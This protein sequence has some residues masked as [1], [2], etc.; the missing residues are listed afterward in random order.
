MTVRALLL[1]A[2]AARAA[3]QQYPKPGQSATEKYNPEIADT[4][5]RFIVWFHAGVEKKI[6]A[7]LIGSRRH[8]WLM[9][10][11]PHG[12]NALRRPSPLCVEMPR[13]ATPR[14]LSRRFR[15]DLRLHDNP[16]LTA[17]VEHA[18][19]KEVVPVF[20]FDPRQFNEERLGPQPARFLVESVAA[21]RRALIELGSDLLVGVGHPEKLLP[22]L[23]SRAKWAVDAAKAAEI[24]NKT[25]I[26]W[27][28]QV[29]ALDGSATS[30]NLRSI[31]L[32]PASS[33]DAP[34]HAYSRHAYSRHAYSPH[35]YSSP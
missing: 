25:S 4:P 19:P 15:N 29:C 5:H 16:L 27:Q 34:R 33:V 12:C 30:P 6:N 23:V 8:G 2:V 35:A 3:A 21:L 28:V 17:A 18:G 1:L 13:A 7:Q 20:I 9:E 22:L 26:M 10:A 32:T 14:R 11:L 24:T 31:Q